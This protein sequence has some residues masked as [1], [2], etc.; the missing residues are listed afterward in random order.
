LGVTGR[1]GR[2]SSN[3]LKAVCLSPFPVASRIGVASRGLGV[4]IV[5]RG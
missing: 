2:P 5:M 1:N 4:A 3:D